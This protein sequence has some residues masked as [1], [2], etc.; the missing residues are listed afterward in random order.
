MKRILVSIILLLSLSSAYAQKSNFSVPDYKKIGKAI[1]KKSS[2][3]YYPVLMERLKANDT[4]LTPREYHLLY[5]GYVLQPGY[6]PEKV[7]SAQ[8]S[9]LALMNREVLEEREYI[10]IIELASS[11]LNEYPFEIS[12]LDPLIY[13]L[14]MEGKNE[15]AA[16]LEFRFGRII[17]TI[18]NSGN[19]LTKETAFHVVS[20]SHQKDMLRA[21]GFGFGGQQMMA[22]SKISYLKV[23]KNDFGIDGMY[24]NVSAINTA[25]ANH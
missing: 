12:I 20:I 25:P 2:S 9:L 8:D 4:T 14:R 15:L 16:K 7:K 21:L 11:T 10:R 13:A 3:A 22:G 1:A 19:G 18:F 6:A 23:A 17:E 5:F 24:F